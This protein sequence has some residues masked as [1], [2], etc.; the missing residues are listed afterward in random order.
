MGQERS[1]RLLLVCPRPP[2]LRILRAGGLL[3]RFTPLPTLEEALA[4]G[5]PHTAG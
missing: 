5:S 4:L 1:G 3:G 2:T